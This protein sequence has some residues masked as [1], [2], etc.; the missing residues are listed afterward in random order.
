MCPKCDALAPTGPD[1]WRVTYRPESFHYGSWDMAGS[2][3]WHEPECLIVACKNCGY[4][5]EMET[6]DTKVPA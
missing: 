3:D 5:Y 4:S 1:G 2:T 6:A